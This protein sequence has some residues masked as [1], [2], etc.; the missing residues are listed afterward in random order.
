MNVY[1]CLLV[2]SLRP[3]FFLRRRGCALRE[4]EVKGGGGT[5]AGGTRGDPSAEKSAFSP[6]LRFQSA[7]WNFVF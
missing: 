3:F 2:K 5:E 1:T 6:S 7:V 4:E